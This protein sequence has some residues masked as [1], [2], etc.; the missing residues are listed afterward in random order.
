MLVL[1]IE[2]STSSAKATLFDT[3]KGIVSISEQKYGRRV[4][5]NGKSYTKTVFNM[6]VQNAK[7]I[8]EGRDIAA[9]A[10]CGTWN[11]L[12]VCNSKMEPITQTFSWDFTETAAICDDIKQNEPL[13]EQLYRNT[14]CLPSYAFPRHSI[15]YL[16]DQGFPLED[17]KFITQGGYNFFRLTGEFLETICTHSGT[18]LINLHELAYDDFTL[19]FLGIRRDQLGELVTYRDTRPLSAEG[20]K[21]LGLKEGIPVV[22]AYPDGALN[23]LGDGALIDGI[24]T[25]SVGTSGALR[26]VSKEPSLA[27]GRQLWCYYGIDSW[28]IGAATNGAC[29]C[30]DWFIQNILND[31][32]GYTAIESEETPGKDVP[33]FLPFLFG[34]RC[35][36]WKN[37]RIGGFM[38]VNN[39]HNRADLYKA[40]QMGIL[41]NLYQCYEIYCKEK[42][43]PE[44]IILS[45]GIINSKIWT[46]MAADIFKR[47]LIVSNTKNASSMGAVAL[48]L[49]AAGELDSIHDFKVEHREENIIRT[50][51]QQ[52]QY[53]QRHYKRYLEAYSHS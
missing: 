48:A 26:T 47:D 46:Q 31:E 33:V 35:P 16:K 29:N 37:N 5:V 18:G 27:E 49:V 34:E 1:A 7:K 32:K 3:K 12:A 38:N 40:I 43:P 10:I 45:G 24:M 42:M 19:D 23:Q 28:M 44:Q 4:S 9:I 30:I 22:P 39:T 51:P 17:K 20:A 11:S 2:S 53:Y 6:T 14:G 41:F 8:A 13:T 15:F 52:Y 25:M 50:N 36:G 21:L